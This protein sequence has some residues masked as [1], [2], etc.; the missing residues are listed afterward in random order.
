LTKAGTK[1]GIMPAKRPVGRPKSS[2][3]PLTIVS[4]R[5]DAEVLAA[6]ERL[7][8]SITLRGLAPGA[9]RGIAIRQ[10]LLDADAR[11]SSATKV[12]R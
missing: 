9:L 7:T 1:K 8:A 6:I 5:A 10:A 4:F 12:R 11:I 3:P 2:A